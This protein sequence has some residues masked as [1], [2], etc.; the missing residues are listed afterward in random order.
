[1]PNGHQPSGG[2]TD[3]EVTGTRIQP[4]GC[5][6]DPVYRCGFG[7]FRP[8]WLQ[9]FATSRLY[10]VVFGLLGITQGAYRAYL[11]GT[12]TSLEKRFSI[13][14][15]VSS[16]IL[17]ADDFSPLLATV[18]F[19]VFLRRTSMPNWI[20]GGI[21]LSFVGALASYLPYAIFGVGTHLLEHPGG[22][23]GSMGA[24]T[25][26]FCTDSG[27]GNVTQTPVDHCASHDS[28]W[29]TAGAVVLL[30][31][32]NFLNGLGGVSCYV[33]GATYMDDNVKKKNSAIYFGKTFYSRSRSTVKR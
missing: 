17:V 33:V 26:Q 18:V 7:Q 2:D 1:M 27:S 32:G 11:V 14:S 21:I 20:S 5:D 9:R 15:R 6:D 3:Q 28:D 30:F 31:L 23:P 24:A 29:S 13:S 16:I 4:F 25:L 12:L 8:D 22:S 10:G 19:L